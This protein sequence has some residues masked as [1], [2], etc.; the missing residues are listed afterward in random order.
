MNLYIVRHAW[1]ADHDDAQWSDDSLRPLTEE[2]KKRFAKVAASLVD[3]GMKLQIVGSSPFV[4]C[5]ETA[6]LLIAAAGKAKLVE[7]DELRPGSDLNG[8]L[9]WTAAQAQKKYE[10]VAWVGHAPDVDRLTAAL[11]GPSDA[12]IRFTK[13][14][15]AAIRFDGPPVLAG[16]ELQWLATAKILGC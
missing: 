12:L 14:A 3:R 10:S 4:R 13:G 7:L 5:V 16:G 2:G 8:L 15:A 1:A 6:R 11:I 9:R